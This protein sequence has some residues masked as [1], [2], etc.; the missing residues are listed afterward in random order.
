MAR[1]ARVG[2]TGNRADCEALSSRAHERRAWARVPGPTEHLSQD[3]RAGAKNAT[4]RARTGERERRATS[5][6]E[7]IAI[8]IGLCAGNSY[9]GDV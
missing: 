5:A 8:L 9:R 6:C 3:A 4:V 2:A 7:N 1:L